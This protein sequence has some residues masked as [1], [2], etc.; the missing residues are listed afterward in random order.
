[1]MRAQPFT[2]PSFRKPVLALSIAGLLITG[3]ESLGPKPST[4]LVPAARPPAPDSVIPGLARSDK[5]DRKSTRTESEIFRGSSE[6]FSRAP[7]R[8]GVETARAGEYTLNFQ[9]A[10]LGEVAKTILEEILKVNYFLNPKVGGKVTLQTTRPLARE[11]L[12]PTLEMVLRANGAALVQDQ[13]VYRI[14]PAQEATLAGGAFRAPGVGAGHQLSVIPLRYVAAPEMQKVLEPLLP[15]GAVVRADP[16]RNILLLSGAASDLQRAQ[17]TV[18]IFDVNFL[19]GMSMALFQVKNV[20]A[21]TLIDELQ[22]ILG[23]SPE[24]PTSGL[25]RFI[26]IERMNAVLAVTPQPAYLD[27]LRQWVERLDRSSPQ[28]T[29]NVRVYRAQN[30]DALVLAETLGAV[31]GVTT[32]A[33]AGVP[34]ASIAP[35]LR[36]TSL[37]SSTLGGGIGGVPTRTSSTRTRSGLGSSALTGDTG[38]TGEVGGVS[39][40][41]RG[42]ALTG[43]GRVRT[44]VGSGLSRTAG[45]APGVGGFG[46]SP[47][48]EIRII[49]DI[50]NNAVII[51]ASP[52]KQEQIDKV[53]RQLDIFPL[54]VLVDVSIVEVQL[55]DEL[56]Y[57]IQW[58]LRHS[59]GDA[60]AGGASNPGGP[61]LIGTQ[62]GFDAVS[63]LAGINGFS[64]GVFGSDVRAAIDALA[65]EGK[66]NVI[67]TPS[68]MVLNNQEAEIRVG[69]EVP[70]RTSESSNLNNAA[71]VVVTNNIEMIPTGVFL[72]IRPRVNASGNVIM[73]VE[74]AVDDVAQTTTSNIDSPTISQRQIRSSVAVHT[75]E[76]L[77]LGGLIRETTD[78]TKSGIPILHKLP[79]IGPLFGRTVNNQN[80]TELVVLITPRV[81]QNRQEA[82]GVT[83]EFKRKLTGLYVDTTLQRGADVPA[84]AYTAPPPARATP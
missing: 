21:A 70:V 83:E 18:A 38:T 66:V 47:D 14:E 59:I 60:V 3:C 53:I 5:D 68:L 34:P 24:S 76:T 71:G 33:S 20:E 79:L 31:F 32:P 39:S 30:V 25:I 72:Y 12:L 8:R 56:Q 6:S 48:D 78:K 55:R 62:P 7:L 36:A 67:S 10:D 9:E 52:E 49:P 50:T 17:D 81:V 45:G 73:D 74:Q 19:K 54:Q 4:K 58:F 26:P 16:A 23:D 82:F 37:G 11:D 29:G 2:P 40:T 22:K 42:S 43:V 51:I 69:D 44:G 46:G 75:G 80:R 28:A 77:V 41:G 61:N 27:D 57:G 13:G 15:A 1:M 64:Y 35:G 65:T 63:A 84:P